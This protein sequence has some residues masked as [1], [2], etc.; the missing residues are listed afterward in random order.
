MSR[1]R[2]RRRPGGAGGGLWTA[3]LGVGARSE[4]GGNRTHPS[5][6]FRKRGGWEGVERLGWKSRVV[7]GSLSHGWLCQMSYSPTPQQ[8]EQF[9]RHGGGGDPEAQ[10]LVS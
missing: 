2:G 6:R 3:A 9:Q 1:G 5:W 8:E 10:A 4:D 7:E